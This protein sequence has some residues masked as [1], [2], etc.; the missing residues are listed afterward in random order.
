MSLADAL[1]NVNRRTEDLI[2]A[3]PASSS[4]EEVPVCHIV[5]HES[6]QRA[7]ASARATRLPAKKPAGSVLATKE[8]EIGTTISQH[9]FDIKVGRARTFLEQRHR[10]L[11]TVTDKRNGKSRELLSGVVKALD[12]FGNPVAER[13]GD[14]GRKTTIDFS[15][16]AVKK[17][18]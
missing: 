9:D 14:R 5:T 16:I 18:P 15:P 3:N 17:K 11:F 4:T 6:Q 2:V 13:V 8:L 12:G 10:V 7:R 1:S